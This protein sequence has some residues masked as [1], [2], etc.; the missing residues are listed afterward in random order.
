M[1]SESDEKKEEPVYVGFWK[2]SR[3]NF[4]DLWKDYPEKNS[5]KEDQTDLIYRLQFLER[6]SPNIFYTDYS[7]CRICN[8][9]NGCNEYHYKNFIWPGGYIHYIKDHN[10]N[11][12]ERLKQF[13]LNID[14]TKQII[15]DDNYF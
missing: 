3:F 6:Y 5:A 2:T 14:I 1:N 15:N 13:L 7:K 8:S 9:I 11:I 12:D 10:V 4:N